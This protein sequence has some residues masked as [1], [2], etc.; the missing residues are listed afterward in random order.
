MNKIITG[1]IA[2]IK[3]NKDYYNIKNETI[4]IAYRTHPDL[5]II[6]DK[7]EGIVTEINNKLCHAAIVAR[8]F[9]KPILMGVKNATKKFKTG[10]NVRIDFDNKTIQKIK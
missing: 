10:D 4:L 6:I 7:I 3:S 9:N 5:V 1:K 2:V 8:E